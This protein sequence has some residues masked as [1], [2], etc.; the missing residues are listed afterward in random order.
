MAEERA[1]A[2]LIAAASTGN[3]TLLKHMSLVF[4][5]AQGESYHEKALLSAVLAGR[6]EAVKLLLEM[7]VDPRAEE[8][9]WAA[10]YWGHKAIL[11]ELTQAA[12]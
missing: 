2:M 5:S 12:T 10:Q 11:T 4:K 8:C 6:M 1:G 3:L 7:G 9:I